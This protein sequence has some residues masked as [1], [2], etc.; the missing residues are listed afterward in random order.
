MPE[1]GEKIMESSNRKEILNAYKERK[2]TGAVCAVKCKE[3]G[4][5]LVIA[6]PDL[7]GYRNRFEFAQATG[8]CISLKLQKDWNAYGAKAFTLEVLEELEKKDTQTPKEFSEDLETLK[9]LWLEKRDPAL[10]Y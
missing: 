9:D 7:K 4:R 8:D 10:L 3:N 5:L 2:V 1:N 6:A